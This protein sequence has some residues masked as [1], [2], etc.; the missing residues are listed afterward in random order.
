MGKFCGNKMRGAVRLGRLPKIT[1]AAEMPP[2]TIRRAREHTWAGT[3]G[4][5]VAAPFRGP[6]GTRLRNSPDARP[7]ARALLPF[8][9]PAPHFASCRRPAVSAISPRADVTHDGTFL[10]V[11]PAD[12]PSR[13]P[14]GTEWMR[15]GAVQ[16]SARFIMI[17][18][19]D[20]N[21]NKELIRG[22]V[23]PPALHCRALYRRERYHLGH[24]CVSA[25]RTVSLT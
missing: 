6:P 12:I 25:L 11:C 1:Y 22:T 13:A 8:T 4:P 10:H 3:G 20:A 21:S 5:P 15:F 19:G 17:D 7:S 23:T 2:C 24:Q 14:R 9:P 18:G 16:S